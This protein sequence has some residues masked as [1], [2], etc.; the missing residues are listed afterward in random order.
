[1]SSSDLHK[2]S[3]WENIYT[4]EKENYEESN[5]ELEEWFEQN[6]DKIINYI[7]KKYM[8]NK[9]ITILDIGCGNGLFLHKLYKKGFT[10]L[11]GFD[12]S[13]TAIKLAKQFFQC[14]KQ[15]DIY[16]Q[17]LDIYDIEKEISTNTKLM[18]QYDLINDKGTFDIFFM[19]NKQQD[20]F[21]QISFFLKT[22]TIFYI[23][24]CNACKEELLE[25]VKTFNKNSKKNKLSF[26]DEILHETITFGGKV[27]QIITT[28][29]FKCY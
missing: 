7:D 4:N 25:I 17:V 23:T 26:I 28:L 16:V 20:Y 10:N 15:K 18:K 21:Y 19:N 11:Y 9:N 12:F 24:T 29:I 13:N 6:C 14:N 1:M 5:V 2:L 8:N 3:Y 27:G 22:N